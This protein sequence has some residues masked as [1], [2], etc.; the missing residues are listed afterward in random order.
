[1]IEPKSQF[2]RPASPKESTDM[3][4]PLADLFGSIGIPIGF[5][6]RD[7]KMGQLVSFLEGRD[8]QAALL[9]SAL[10]KLNRPLQG[11]QEK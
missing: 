4:D 2:E 3:A 10:A 1:M 5:A 7:A 11:N 8:A 6:R 9:A